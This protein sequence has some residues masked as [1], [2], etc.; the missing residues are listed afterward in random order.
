[1]E[2]ICFISSSGG[3]FEQLKMLKTLSEDYDIFYVTEKTEYNLHE[4]SINGHKLYLLNQINRKDKFL[5][6]KLIRV[7]L[8][9]FLIFKKEQPNIIISTGALSVIPMFLIGKLYNKKLV[10]IESYAKVNSP[11]KSGKF[12]YRI[13]D[14]FIVQWESMLQYYPK[15]HYFGGIY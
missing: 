1:M 12:L 10:F 7:F 14:V 3:H 4:N 9:S 15:A 6:L 5:I 11:T 13:T 8:K 2:K